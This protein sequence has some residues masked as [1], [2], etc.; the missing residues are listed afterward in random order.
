M[1]NMLSVH[2][3]SKLNSNFHINI[4]Y[5]PASSHVNSLLPLEKYLGHD[6]RPVLVSNFCYSNL[7][8]YSQYYMFLNE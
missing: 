8:H 5:K 4:I 7:N 1:L 6:Q 2:I 3:D